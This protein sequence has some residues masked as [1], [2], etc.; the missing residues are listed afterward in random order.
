MDNLLLA[1]HSCFVTISICSLA[2]CIY[3]TNKSKIA[4]TESQK[5]VDAIKTAHNTNSES[6]ENMIRKIQDLETMIA[7]TRKERLK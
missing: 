7:I 1:L 4:M 2:V 5:L 3:L 6:M